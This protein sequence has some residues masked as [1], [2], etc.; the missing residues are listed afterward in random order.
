MARPAAPAAK[1]EPS[2]EGA[3]ERLEAIVDRLEAGELPLEQALA[4]FEEGVSLSRRCAGELETAERRIEIRVGGG[5]GGATT[6][7]FEPEVEGE[8][9]EPGRGPEAGA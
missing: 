1:P 3:L 6:E 2:F 9:G 5:A 8:P 7:P 4:A